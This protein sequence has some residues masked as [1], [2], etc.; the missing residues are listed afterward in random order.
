MGLGLRLSFWSVALNPLAFCS[1]GNRCWAI[2][3]SPNCSSFQKRLGLLLNLTLRGA[4]SQTKPKEL[5]LSIWSVAGCGR[6]NVLVIFFYVTFIRTERLWRRRSSCIALFPW[7]TKWVVQVNLS[8]SEHFFFI[9]LGFAA[10]V[11]VKINLTFFETLRLRTGKC[12]AFHFSPG[13]DSGSA[14]SFT[15]GPNV[16]VCG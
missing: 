16:S 5:R 3:I 6:E 13:S 14:K 7:E 11:R 8:R 15:I 2:R 9:K 1:S 10:R 4:W 12:F